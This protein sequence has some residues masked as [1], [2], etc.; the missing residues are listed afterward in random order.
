MILGIDATN[1]REGGGVTHLK[2]ILINANPQQY[3]F[4]KVV[5]WSNQKTLD[6]L[7]NYNWLLKINNKWLNKSFI[8]SFLY[9]SL[10]MS[11]DIKNHKCDLLFVPGGT[12]LGS[13]SNIVS[14]SQNM[15]PFEKEEYMRFPKWSSRLKFKLL[16]ITQS[17][18]FRKSK[19]IIFLTNY[20]K[21]YIINFAN[22]N[23]SANIVIPHGIRASFINKPKI[24]KHIEFYNENN[25]FKFLY[26]SIITEYKHQWNVAEAILKLRQ[27]GYPVT[28]DLVGGYTVEALEK[29]KKVL[30]KDKENVINYRGLIPYDELSD[31]YINADGF[32]FASTCENM[33]IILIEAMTAGLPI[34]SSDKE[35]MG[36]VLE[37][38]AFYF[39]SVSVDSIYNSLKD[40]LLNPEKR[41]INSENTFNKAIR[42]TWKDCYNNTFK[43]LSEKSKSYAN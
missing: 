32:I 36:E 8:I 9:Q 20:A 41:T 10:L 40:Y 28:L 16:Q 24:Q 37:N 19:G 3:G 22:L 39:N 5:I 25:P 42:Y 33:P 17:Y 29:L 21:N 34:A 43:Y 12:F 11:S 18:T 31:V 14:M 1:I 7:P 35:P 2:E 13:F 26:V 30:L 38:S 6:I 4:S 27:E 15:L 23:P